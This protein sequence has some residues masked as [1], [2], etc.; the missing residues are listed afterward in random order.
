MS[1][2]AIFDAH[3]LALGR[4]C[5]SWSVVDRQLNDLLAAFTKASPAAV[6]CITSSIDAVGSRCEMLR[7][8]GYE[9]AVGDEWS[10]AFD[11]LMVRLSQDLAPQRNRYVHDYWSMTDGALRV[12]D[13]RA[14]VGRGQSRES[15]KLTYDAEGV[16]PVDAVDRLCEEVGQM[17]FMLHAALRDVRDWRRSRQRAIPP[18]L[19][20][21]YDLRDVPDVLRPIMRGQQRP[22]RSSHC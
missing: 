2:V 14:R 11:K 16:V 22:R 3:C 10:T 19:C 12:L 8:L 1:D 5:V 13:R 6:A 21:A 4:L 20:R 15:A 17:A 7:K 18:L 9:D